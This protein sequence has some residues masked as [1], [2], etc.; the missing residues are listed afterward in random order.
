[1]KKIRES[2]KS[3]LQFSFVLIVIVVTFAFAMFQGGLVSWTIFYTI[4]PFTLYALVLFFYPLTPLKVTREVQA[5][6]IESGGRL[7]VVLTVKR[8]IRFPLLY[9][10]ISECWADEEVLESAPSKLDNMS[11]LFIFGFRKEL[12]WK[13]ELIGMPR[14]EHLLKGVDIEVIDFF[15]WIRKKKFIPIENKVL[16]Y[17]KVVELEYVQFDKQSEQGNTASPFNLLKDTTMVTGVRN[18]EAGD[19]V[20]WIHWKSFARTG[21]LMTKEFEDRRAQDLFLILDSRE[22]PKFEEQIILAA[23]MLKVCKDHQAEIGFMSM[24]AQVGEIES[25]RSTFPLLKTEDQYRSVFAHLASIKAVKKASVQRLWNDTSNLNKSGTIIV[26]TGNPDWAFLKP[27]VR[28]SIGTSSIIC[29]VVVKEEF[30]R[31]QEILSNVEFAKRKG[32]NVQVILQE[33]FANA[34]NEVAYS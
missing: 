6:N 13:Y 9:I 21:E 26:I 8:N 10:V 19:R 7:G 3:V 32:V 24:P 5:K 2:L 4:L 30:D 17:P 23:S 16:V 14:G 12:V 1:M 22:S 31:R 20:S 27:L 25:K 29:F 34:F 11:K 18:Y 33:Q 15:G 28:G